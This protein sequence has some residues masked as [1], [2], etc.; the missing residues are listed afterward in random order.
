MIIWQAFSS[1]PFWRAE[2]MA[3]EAFHRIQAEIGFAPPEIPNA[4]V[5]LDTLQGRYWLQLEWRALEQALLLEHEPRR[6]AIGDALLFRAARRAQFQNAAMEERSLEMHEG[7]A[8]Y[9]GFHLSQASLA[10]VAEYLRTAPGRYSSFVRSFAYASG[11]AYGLLLDEVQPDWRIGLTPK[12]DMGDMLKTAFSIQLPGNLEAEARH[13]AVSYDGELLHVQEVQ[14]DQ[15]RQAEIAAYRACLI[16]GP[17]LILPISSQVR[18]AFDP[19]ATVPI[20]DSGTVFPSIRVSDRWGILDVEHG[21]LW[22]SD[23]WTVSRV[24]APGSPKTHPLTADGWS[25]Q[26]NSG[27]QLRQ[28]ETT[29][30]WEL[31][32]IMDNQSVPSPR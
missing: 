27:W 26:L 18:C 25:L 17:A 6:V 20:P 21:G 11:P 9:T 22:M 2:F 24:I 14:R 13:R 5:H 31:F 4:N 29:L 16:E 15:E 7:L 32:Q 28:I 3:H 1:D 10:Q 12:N 8:E 23:D 19:R 30:D